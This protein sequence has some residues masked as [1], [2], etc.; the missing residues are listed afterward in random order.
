MENL[1]Y[2]KYCIN[3]TVNNE[4]FNCIL[5]LRV[6]KFLTISQTYHCNMLCIKKLTVYR[7]IIEQ[8]LSEHKSISYFVLGF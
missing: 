6:V 5:S 8:F 4:K 1:L 3:I 2:K 7:T